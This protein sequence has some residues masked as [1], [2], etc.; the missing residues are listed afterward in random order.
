MIKS[1][2]NDDGSVEY[3]KTILGGTEHSIRLAQSYEP[4]R[5]Y[6]KPVVFTYASKESKE[7]KARSARLHA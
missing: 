6:W 3:A 4:F 2:K 1:T 5:I 7:S